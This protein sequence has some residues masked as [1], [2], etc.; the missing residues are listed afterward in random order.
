MKLYQAMK[1]LMTIAAAALLPAMY[2]VPALAERRGLFSWM[3]YGLYILVMLF[4]WGVTG[5][6][7]RNVS[8]GFDPEADNQKLEETREIIREKSRWSTYW[9]LK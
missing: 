2:L 1:W 8:Q 6:G 7:N 3:L 4:V 9:T 5:R